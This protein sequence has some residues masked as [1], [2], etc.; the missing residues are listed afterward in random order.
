MRNTKRLL[1]ACWPQRLPNG[2]TLVDH[3]QHGTFFEV[4]PDGEV[5]WAYVSPVLGA[6]G[7][8]W[9]PARQGEPVPIG[10]GSPPVEEEEDE[11]PEEDE[12]EAKPEPELEPEGDSALAA[13]R[14]AQAEAV[15][16]SPRWT[17]PSPRRNAPPTRAQLNSR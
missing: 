12:E 4:A 15:P 14:R 13:L 2:N 5:V 9:R 3:G 6:D 10:M 1:T 17:P 7:V 11:Q 16:P 8:A